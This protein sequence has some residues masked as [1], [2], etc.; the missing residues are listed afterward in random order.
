MHKS[1]A[2]IVLLKNLSTGILASVLSLAE[3]RKMVGE[4]FRKNQ[5]YLPTFR[6]IGL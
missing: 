2:L 4:M 5:P 3:I 1:V 6:K